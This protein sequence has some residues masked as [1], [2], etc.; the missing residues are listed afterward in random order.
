[1]QT[2]DICDFFSCVQIFVAFIEHPEDTEVLQLQGCFAPL[3]R[4][5]C[6]LH[7]ASL[8]H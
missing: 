2:A 8:I 4:D 5:F 6:R 3:T 1:M 7:I